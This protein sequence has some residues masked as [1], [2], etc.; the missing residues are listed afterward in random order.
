MVSKEKRKE[1]N[2]RYYAKK[3]SNKLKSILE[4]SCEERNNSI[5]PHKHFSFLE[6][7]YNAFWFIRSKFIFKY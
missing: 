7:F 2:R 4:E 6:F 3:S 1:Y 5:V